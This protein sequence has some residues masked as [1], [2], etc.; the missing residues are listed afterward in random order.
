M[1]CSSTWIYSKTIASLQSS[2]NKVFVFTPS[3]S[4][5]NKIAPIMIKTHKIHFT[6]LKLWTKQLEFV[7]IITTHRRAYNERAMPFKLKEGN[8]Q[9]NMRGTNF[10][11]DTQKKIKKAI[12]YGNTNF[13]RCQN[14]SIHMMSQ[15]NT[16]IH[17][18]KNPRIYRQYPKKLVSHLG[19]FLLKH[20]SRTNRASYDDFDDNSSSRKL[21]IFPHFPHSISTPCIFELKICFEKM[22][23]RG[24]KNGLR[25]NEIKHF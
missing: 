4:E 14:Y 2:N 15:I 8:S 12:L 22:L 24:Q 19:S 17:S 7:K 11:Q 21:V 18:Y 5:P 16:P 25:I 10:D 6:K 3:M 23:Q 13:R 9:F 20:F 1:V